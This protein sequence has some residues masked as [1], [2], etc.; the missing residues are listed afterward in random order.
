M[1]WTHAS[2]GGMS[3]R[4]VPPALIPRTP[5]ST[6]LIASPFPTVKL[7]SFDHACRAEEELEQ[8]ARETRIIEDAYMNGTE[9]LTA[10]E[11]TKYPFE[12]RRIH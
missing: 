2:D 5:S 3:M 12:R 4:R 9:S 6:P 10:E 1:P 8:C 11:S 7:N